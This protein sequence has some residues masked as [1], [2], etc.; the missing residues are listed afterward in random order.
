MPNLT[1]HVPDITITDQGIE[2]PEV[3]DILTGV[4]QDLND[5]FGGNLNIQNVGT[6]QGLLAADLTH[7]IALKNAA[8]AFLMAM[9]DPATS[10]GRWLDALGQIYFIERKAATPTVV[11][12]QCT[13]IS[14][15]TLKARGVAR[16]QKT[17]GD[18]EHFIIFSY[19]LAQSKGF[20]E[21]VKER[22]RGEILARF[23][24]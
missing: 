23:L 16:Q 15:Y 2:L 17:R 4:L 24:G 12:C 8:Q 14:G 7:N 3:Q 19:E 10:Q 1:S 18:W 11:T 5:A 13:G 22:G 6:P 9:F 20:C 21:N